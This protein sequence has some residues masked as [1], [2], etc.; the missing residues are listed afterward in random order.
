[1]PQRLISADVFLS[2]RV[3]RRLSHWCESRVNGRCRA[4]RPDILP[5][6]GGRHRLVC[7]RLDKEGDVEQADASCGKDVQM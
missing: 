5:R 7:L 1:M 4:L 2:S 3:Q 6:V